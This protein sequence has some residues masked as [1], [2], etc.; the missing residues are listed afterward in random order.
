VLELAIKNYRVAQ[1]NT[2]L[3]EHLQTMRLL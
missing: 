2:G 3:A 1:R